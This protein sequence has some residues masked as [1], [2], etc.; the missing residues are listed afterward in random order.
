MA[1]L[2]AAPIQ[3][4]SAAK[5]ASSPKQSAR[6]SAAALTAGLSKEGGTEIALSSVFDGNFKKGSIEAELVAPM[7]G[8]DGNVD[9]SRLSTG[10]TGGVKKKEAE[11]QLEKDK[12]KLDKYERKIFADKKNKILIV[13]QG[14]DTGGKDGIIKHV[15]KGLNPQGMK[16][17]GFK[18]PTE[19]EAKNGPM[20]RIK[21][22]LGGPGMISVFNRSHYEDALVPL[23]KKTMSKEEVD[24]R[25]ADINKFEK[26]LVD[27]GWTV[28]KLFLHVSKEENWNRLEERRT[29]KKKQWKLSPDDLVSREHWEDNQD[30]YSYVIGRTNTPYAPWFI[31]PSDKKWYR[32]YAAGRI[33]K[34]ALKR[35]H[36]RW[37]KPDHL[38]K[39]IPR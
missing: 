16:V 37:P 35:L 8:R 22:A 3:A 38:P 24:A 25:I 5:E 30:A 2:S 34:R 31:I 26:D 1:T 7:P 21:K 39:K 20:W 36:P 18:K 28:I 29:T 15:L 14:M 13:L 11:K 33:I 4:A 12:T 32:N 10:E 17:S 9:L 19:E 6:A 23:A 27:D